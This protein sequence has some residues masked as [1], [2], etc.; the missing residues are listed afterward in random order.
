M[1]LFSYTCV[2]TSVIGT[3]FA[4]STFVEQKAIVFFTIAALLLSELLQTVKMVS[5]TFD[6]FDLFSIALFV[7]LS[8]VTHKSQLF[9]SN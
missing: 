3:S 9:T 1:G 8:V 2:S 6:C 5:G 4:K 7:G